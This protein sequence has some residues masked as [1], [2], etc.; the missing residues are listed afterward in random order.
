MQYTNGRGTFEPACANWIPCTEPKVLR[1]N[2]VHGTVEVG[3][4]FPEF[5]EVTAIT[6]QGK[7]VH[8]VA[9]GQVFVNLIFWPR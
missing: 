3:D 4:S 9:K 7:I 5:G 8:S 2:I 6:L 1:V